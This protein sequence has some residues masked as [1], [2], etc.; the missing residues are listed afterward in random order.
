M[1][2]GVRDLVSRAFLCGDNDTPF[3]L[4]AMQIAYVMTMFETVV[5]QLHTFA[6]HAVT[7]LAHTPVV[8]S[9]LRTMQLIVRA[10]QGMTVTH[11]IAIVM[12]YFDAFVCCHRRR[13]DRLG[14]GKAGQGDE[15]DG[16]HAANDVHDASPEI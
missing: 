15:S 5:A 16:C 13:A 6:M 11:D 2:K 3:L 8:M 1:K 4:A 7:D 14:G 9:A 10:L 12:A